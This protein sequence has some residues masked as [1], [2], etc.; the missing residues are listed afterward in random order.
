MRREREIRKGGV[1]GGLIKA[2]NFIAGSHRMSSAIVSAMFLRQTV[3]LPIL[4]APTPSYTYHVYYVQ[5]LESTSLRQVFVIFFI[6][7]M[8][9]PMPFS[10][11]STKSDSITTRQKS[12]KRAQVA[13][14]LVENLWMSLLEVRTD[15]TRYLPTGITVLL[16]RPWGP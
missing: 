10:S 12:E 11:G 1:Q 3:K 7:T 5:V 16:P 14:D 9:L 8:L 6:S 4:T 2:T 15:L 13:E